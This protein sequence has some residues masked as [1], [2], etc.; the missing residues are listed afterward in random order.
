M[1]IAFIRRMTIRSRIALAIITLALPFANA[2]A[3]SLSAV[4]N[5][6]SFHLGASQDWN[7]DNYGLGVEY[8]FRT[9][10]HWKSRLMA[11]GF[12][13]SSENMSYMAGAGIHRNLLATDRLGGLYLDAGIN[14]FLMTRKDINDNKPFPGVLPS[15]TVGNRYVGVNLTYLPRK[16]V[17]QLYDSQMVDQSIS[18]IVFLQ[19]KISVNPD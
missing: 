19:F 9:E 11:N 1:R 7:E 16:A 8:E 3:G 5:G 14:G 17:E 13:D 4:L 15:V 10:S 6:K 12:R 18:G 2:Q